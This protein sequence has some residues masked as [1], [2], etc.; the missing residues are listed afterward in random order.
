MRRL[1]PDDATIYLC[2]NKTDL[3][4]S[5]WKISRDELSHLSAMHKIPLYEVSAVSGS[6]VGDV[7][8]DMG[9]RLLEISR[10]S[11]ALPYIISRVDENGAG[12]GS[13]SG[14]TSSILSVPVPSYKS[15][16]MTNIANEKL[17]IIDN[18]DSFVNK[19]ME[20]NRSPLLPSKRLL[21]KESH[22]SIIAGLS[23]A[24][25]VVV[26]ILCA[27]KYSKNF[28]GSR[29]LNLDDVP[30]V[31][32]PCIFEPDSVC[33][34][35]HTYVTVP[36]VNG[37]WPD[38][39][40]WSLY[41]GRS[42]GRDKKESVLF[43]M[44]GDNF[45]AT[46]SQQCHSFTTKLCLSGDFFVYPTSDHYTSSAIEVCG[47]QVTVGQ[48]LQFSTKDSRCVTHYD[49]DHQYDM[50]KPTEPSTDSLLREETKKDKLKDFAH[51]E[52]NARTKVACAGD[53]IT[54]GFGATTPYDSYP[55]D[56]QRLLGS[57][58]EVR[59]FGAD[60]TTAQKKCKLKPKCSNITY[61]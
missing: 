33:H 35:S 24:M 26:A 7:F 47:K 15:A 23:L 19:C 42:D 52:D 9:T 45:G 60:G 53:S 14:K 51:S 59:N 5:E 54:F 2:A 3:D 57:D 8:S 49:M 36:A 46:D 32:K 11:G 27:G 56:L 41:A 40:S 12:P 1:V 55:S 37:R 28:R 21:K 50:I 18:R 4:E 10:Q 31:S 34:A 22:R 48:T 25:L 43:T 29:A 61:D 17:A 58:Y 39:L 44:R 13:S 30:G 38:S 6:N 16:I 20:G